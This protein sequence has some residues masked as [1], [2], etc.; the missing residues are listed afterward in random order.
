MK[1]ILVTSFVLVGMGG[2]FSGC[3]K[4]KE[5]GTNIVEKKGI[6]FTEAKPLSPNIL[7]SDSIA[8]LIGV[9]AQTESQIVDNINIS[10]ESDQVADKDI[11]V[12]VALT[13][14]L[15]PA[16][17]EILP[18]DSYSVPTTVTIPKGERH[19]RLPLTFPN[20][21]ALDPNIIYGLGF[22]ITN[23]S[24]TDVQL[25]ENKKSIIVTFAVKNKYD[26]TY[27]LRCRMT[28]PANDRPTVNVSTTWTWPGNVLVITSGANTDDL[29]DDWGFGDYIQPIQSS[30]PSWSAF[31]ST[32]PRFIFDLAT[33]QIT[34]VVNNYPSP[35]NGRAFQIDP[36]KPS[37]W[38]V[39]TGNIYAHFIMTQPGF[40]P[41]F[42]ADTLIYKGSR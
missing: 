4:D 41:L 27:G 22:T 20:S 30:T 32:A 38:D 31:G 3:L 19:V 24:A 29:F 34:D 13:N 25:A 8:L 39:N 40:Q 33:D 21:S 5:Y 36:A 1:K 9:N 14:N 18:A 12:T 10:L 26:G 35:S 11:T 2:V 42:I 16:D 28:A 37:K 17:Y 6:G 15:L 23:I 7:P